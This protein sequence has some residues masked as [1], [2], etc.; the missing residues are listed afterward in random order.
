MNSLSNPFED[1]SIT[2]VDDGPFFINE[3]FQRKFAHPAPGHGYSVV[4]F[5]RKDWRHFLPVCYVNFTQYDEV[6]LGGGAVT[7][8]FAFRNMPKSLIA[9]VK[10]AGGIYLHMLKF[11]IHRFRDQCE[12][13]FGYTA[14]KLALE[15]DIKAGFEATKYEHLI[16][17]FHKP[18]SLERKNLL[19]DKVNAVGPF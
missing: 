5:Y 17:H 13:Y 16:A 18:I 3:L 14:D 8:A 10:L 9:E 6:M 12:G 2:T 11:C 1:I 7:D 19:I 15:V 4:C